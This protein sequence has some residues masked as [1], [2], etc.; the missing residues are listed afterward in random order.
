MML[1]SPRSTRPDTLFPYTTL[2][3]SRQRILIVVFREK[4]DFTF[5]DVH[6]PDDQPTIASILHPQDGSEEPEAHYTVG[7]KAKVDKRYTLTPNLWAYLQNYAAKH[8]AAGNGFGFG[9]VGPD[10][11]SRTL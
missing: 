2:F 8:K 10:S 11:V 5:D 6:L 1:R 7:P 9:L 3:L 4:T